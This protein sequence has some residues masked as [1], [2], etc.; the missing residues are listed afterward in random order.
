MSEVGEQLNT[1]V[2]IDPAQFADSMLVR[3]GT[4]HKAPYVPT[5][6]T[7]DMLD[8][9]Y[10]LDSVDDMHRRKYSRKVSK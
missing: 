6:S 3:E 8:G 9:T 10:F 1:R 5:G 2:K 7:E 4:H